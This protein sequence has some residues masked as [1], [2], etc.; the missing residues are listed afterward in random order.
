MYSLLTPC[1]ACSKPDE[2][3]WHHC[4]FTWDWHSQVHQCT[5][6]TLKTHRHHIHHVLCFCISYTFPLKSQRSQRLIVQ[7]MV[8]KMFHPGVCQQCGHTF[9]WQYCCVCHLLLQREWESLSVCIWACVCFSSQRWCICGFPT[10]CQ[11]PNKWG[12]WK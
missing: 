3:H 10:I 8:Y 4:R 11:R 2:D 6:Y 7:V 1:S 5:V 9:Q 12:N